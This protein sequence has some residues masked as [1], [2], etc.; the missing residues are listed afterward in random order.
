M[1]LVRHED[2]LHNLAERRAKTRPWKALPNAGGSKAG[3]SLIFQQPVTDVQRT[4]LR[5]AR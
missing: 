5:T 1:T 2:Q 4:N 3:G